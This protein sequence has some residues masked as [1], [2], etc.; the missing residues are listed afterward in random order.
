MALTLDHVVPHSLGGADVAANLVT[1]CSDC[2][3]RRATFPVD[4]FAEL[5]R[6][7]G[8]TG[9]EARVLKAISTPLPTK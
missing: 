3:V 1:C 8:A 2:N 6:R 7:E 4:L 9:V 5:L